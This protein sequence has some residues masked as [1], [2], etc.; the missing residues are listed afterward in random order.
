[1]SDQP[2]PVQQTCCPTVC[3]NQEKFNEAFKQAVQE[4]V[5]IQEKDR[6]AYNIA[7]VI[8]FLLLVWAVMLAMKVSD[9]EHRVLHV[10]L[11]LLMGPLYIIAYFLGMMKA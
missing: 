1:M 8:Y 10:G 2:Q 9:K 4:N 6:K 7:L 3:E 5:K 11:A